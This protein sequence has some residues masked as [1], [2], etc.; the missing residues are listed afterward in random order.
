MILR[1]VSSGTRMGFRWPRPARPQPPGDRNDPPTASATIRIGPAI[2]AGRSRRRFG[3]SLGPLNRPPVS[4][5]RRGL[6]L[7]CHKGPEEFSPRGFHILD[8]VRC[9]V[10]ELVVAFRQVVILLT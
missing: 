7:A 3:P 2:R 8:C 10:L 6:D 9:R 4:A 5:R 1:I